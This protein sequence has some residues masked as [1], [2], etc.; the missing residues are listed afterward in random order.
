[1]IKYKVN[2]KNTS[3]DGTSLRGYVV[4]TYDNLVKM[5]GTPNKGSTD[6]KTTCEWVFEFE[7][8]TVATIHDWKTK[9]TPKDPYNW[10]IG[11]YNH[12]ALLFLEE[13]MNI[14]TSK[15]TI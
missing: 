5:F 4:T 8:G 13:I 6:G 11:G 10:S 14:K 1:M 2:Q 9:M 15:I 3:V 12:L 7:D